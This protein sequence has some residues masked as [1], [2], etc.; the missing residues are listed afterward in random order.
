MQDITDNIEL[1]QAI[2]VSE[3]HD[4]ILKLHEIEL[5]QGSLYEI[6][7]SA[8]F[9][10]QNRKIQSTI[11]EMVDHLK[12]MRFE[13]NEYY[14]K[15]IQDY[16]WAKHIMQVFDDCNFVKSGVWSAFQ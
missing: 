3:L 9:N 8:D 14:Q 15:F 2:K 4:A 7:D 5:E 16:D 10:L 12:N 13:N 6:K 1:K 11:M